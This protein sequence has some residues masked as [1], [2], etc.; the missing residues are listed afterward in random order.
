MKALSNARVLALIAV[1]AIASGA[2]AVCA[3]LAVTRGAAIFWDNV[4]WTLS[5]GFAAFALG[6]AYVRSSGP[7]RHFLRWTFL[8]FLFETV[9]QWVYNGQAL[10]GLYVI[11]DA[12]ALPFLLRAP[13]AG[14]GLITF[15][16]RPGALV[17]ALL[18]ATA[19][20]L[21]LLAVIL[22]IYLPLASDVQPSTVAALVAYPLCFFALAVLTFVVA[23]DERENIKLQLLALGLSP[24]ALGTLWVVWNRQ[25]LAGEVP[26]AS[27]VGDLFS[28]TNLVWAAAA[29]RWQPGTKVESNTR[30]TYEMVLQLLPVALVIASAVFLTLLIPATEAVR[31]AVVKCIGGTLIIAVLRQSMLLRERERRIKSD[32]EAARFREQL[33]QRQKLELMGVVASGVAH[34]MNNLLTAIIGHADL[35]PL[36]RSEEEAK[37]FLTNLRLASLRAQDA[38]QRILRFARPSDSPKTAES[39]ALGPLAKEVGYLLAIAVN[40]RH[41]ISF[42]IEHALPA[43]AGNASQIHQ[44][45]M[46]LAINASHAIGEKSGT[47]IVSAQRALKNSREGARLTVSDTGC[48]M[49]PGTLARVFEPFFTTKSADSGTGLGLTVVQNIVLAHEGT[50]EVESCINVGTSFH[51]WLPTTPG[52]G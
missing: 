17:P 6:T 19:F 8:G 30:A 5:S 38:V 16:R 18:D 25:V 15:L 50:I 42:E 14:I 43:I 20:G 11:P 10:V 35:I 23:L 32:T 37:E 12:A 51:I 27:L 13:L 34:D 21:L 29:A 2:A 31:D 48:G 46:N 1:G 26:V 52:V 24:F 45:I 44:I 41:T 22:S 4:Q 47:I 28:V 33:A 40:P 49:S 7:S 39:F 9:G 3:H 36:S